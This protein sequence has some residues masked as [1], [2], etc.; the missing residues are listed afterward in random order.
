MK[1]PFSYISMKS[2]GG[3]LL[4]VGLSA[5]YGGMV[6]LRLA[7]KMLRHGS[8]F[9]AVKDREGIHRP[10]VLDAYGTH[11]SIRLP[12]T[13]IKLHYVSAGDESKQLI[14]FVHGFPECWFTWRH[15]MRAFSSQYHTVAVSM[16]GYGDS[17]RP[18]GVKHYSADL[19][20]EDLVGV[21]SSLVTKENPKCILVSHDW[22]GVIAWNVAQRR[23]D[24][25]HRFI[26]L[27][28]PHPKAWQGRLATSWRQ[29]RSSWYMFFFNLPLLPELFMRNR[30][31]KV[32]E[33]MF[34]KHNKGAG[35]MDV[36]KYYFAKPYGVEGP[37]NYYR[38]MLR[39]YGLRKDG[40]QENKKGTS[41]LVEPKTLILWGEDDDALISELATDSATFCKDAEVKYLPDCSHWIQV[42]KPKE[43]NEAMKEFLKKTK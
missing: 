19:L 2:T 14:L 12:K 29:F 6:A 20:Y 10:K 26:A 36:Y 8:A 11:R 17:D 3:Q 1:S 37:L 24:L 34:G 40:G 25:V 33:S 41:S 27:N 42:H 32:L 22:G 7:P 5:F 35:E 21:I 30:D 16:R 38:A 31:F 43:V 18:I 28:A 23:P 15:Q 9:F 13:N 4:S 39:G